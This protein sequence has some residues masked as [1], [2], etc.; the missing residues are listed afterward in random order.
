MSAV[1]ILMIVGFNYFIGFYYGLVNLFYTVIFT[2]ALFVVLKHLKRIQYS[3]RA[4]YSY[5]PQ[6]PPV[7]ILIPAYNEEEVIVRTV[8]SALSIQYPD[9]EVIIV[10][11]GSD[12]G[13]LESLISTFHLKKIDL[14]YRKLIKTA[15]VNNFYYNREIPNLLVIDKDRGNK[16][17]A[18]NCGI[19]AS[20]SPYF[21][22]LDA[23]S[24]LEKESLLR[25]MTP[26]MESTVPVIACGGVVRVLNGTELSNGV[27]E[28]IDL[29]G[30]ALAMFQIVEYLR[31]F[32]FGRV[33]LDAMN[34]LL[35]LSGAFSL[36]QKSAVIK[37]G[38]YD[39]LNVTE[40]M[41]LIVKLH[42]KH[43]RKGE[44]YRIKFISDPICWTEVPENLKMLARQRRRWHLGLIETIWKYRSL[45]FNP[46]FGR[47]GTFVM[48]YYLIVELLSPLIEV[49]GYIAVFFA[50]FLGI[51]S[52]EFLLLFLTL[53]IFYGIFLTTSGI[54]LEEIT[55]RRYPRWSH[56]ATLLLYGVLENIGY[57]Q[58]N[59][60]FRV[61]GMIRF[62]TGKR[63]WEH[64]LREN[65]NA[66]QG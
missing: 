56:L 18:L 28:K 49:F 38:G 63:D 46:K 47:L 44:P 37:A 16:A 20:R 25:L 27:V 53:A 7:S 22:S 42:E 4:D 57:R 64:T 29:P 45:T 41:E 32:L 52:L 55:Y 26:I 6:T 35:I 19:N 54:F 59:S 3:A 23:D 33:G 66:Q 17:D 65:K 39:R 31:A 13:T 11:D 51:L 9:F 14:V 48:P 24:V 21:C 30:N 62:L 40:D 5:S 60:F 36:F 2:V 12:D 15:N 34:S 1:L 8:K 50:Y 10:N 43:K 61:Q 58:I